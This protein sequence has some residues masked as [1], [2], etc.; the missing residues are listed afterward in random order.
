MEQSLF[1]QWVNKFFPGIT[2]RI[3][4]TL[5]DTKNP[6]TYLHRRFLRKDFS[7]TGKWESINAANTMVMADVV[8]M[9]SPLPL[10]KR[11]TIS[12]AF[13][14]IAKMGMELALN[15]RQLTDLDTLIAQGGTDAQILGKLFA[16]TPRVI[17]GIYERL[18]EMFLMGL[19]SGVTL[20]EDT[21]NVGTGV[22]LDYGYPTA[23]KFGTVGAVWSTAN[24][25][26]VTPFADIQRVLDKV[27]ADGNNI[28]RV[29]LDQTAF[30]YMAAT[31]QAKE[32]FA[33]SQSFVGSNIPAPDF[34][35]VNRFTSARYGFTFEIVNRSVRWEKNG[36]QT[37]IKP[38][39]VGAAVFLTSEQ[40]G[41]LTWARLAE[42][43]HPVANVTYSTVDDYILVSKYR[44][45]V[46]SL[47]EYT[48]SQARVVPV[49]NNVD[50]IY[51]LDTTTVQA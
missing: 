21:E 29:L 42:Q 40:L 36:N 26:G 23:N 11:D 14:N 24:G 12:K 27:S 20:V 39:T 15:E 38:W 28:T 4:E 43:N 19:S 6:V 17:S 22:R 5:N 49:I 34:G 45:N 10:K 18:E 44:K 47:S 33:F 50:Q 1:I 37:T 8:A 30:N 41:S 35:Q 2:L 7:V 46:P 13:G 51:V 16:D 9:D 48:S 3:V 25:T 31:A 32:L